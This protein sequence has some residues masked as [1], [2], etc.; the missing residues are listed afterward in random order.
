M[1]VF[2]IPVKLAH[3]NAVRFSMPLG[4]S[5]GV[6]SGI[7]L[8]AFSAPA[9]MHGRRVEWIVLAWYSLGMSSKTIGLVGSN[10]E[11]E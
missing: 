10:C 2:S 11:D 3:R 7:S 5:A 9:C 1:F 8:A 4:K 6:L